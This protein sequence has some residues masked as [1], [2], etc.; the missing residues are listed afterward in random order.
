MGTSGLTNAAARAPW[1]TTDQ[2]RHQSCRSDLQVRPQHRRGAREFRQ[3]T[4]GDAHG[5]HVD[6]RG[7]RL[8]DRLRGKC[9]AHQ[10]PSGSQVQP[11]RRAAHESRHRRA[12]GQRTQPVQPAQRRD[13]R[14]RRQ[15][16]R[17]RRTRRPGHDEQRGDGQRAARRARPRGS[18]SSHPTARAQ[19]VGTDRRAPR[20]VP[21][22]SCDGVR[23][24][25]PSLG[26][27]SRQ[28]PPR[29]LRSGRQ[30]S[31]VALHVWPHQRDL[32]Q[33][34]HGLRDRTPSPARPAT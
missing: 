29:D 20:R 16:L 17:R 33:G 22:A 8:G 12:A 28:P 32:H 23:F 18:S 30:L 4:H 19:G 25:G 11:A 2:L 9:R 34:R 26:R 21:H 27:G 31:R 5:I 3:G 6:A 7:Q 15:H 14:A 24:R 13:H 10:G 1:R